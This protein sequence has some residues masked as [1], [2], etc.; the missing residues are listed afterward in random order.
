MGVGG[1]IPCSGS[2]GEHGRCR[3]LLAG[4]KAHAIQFE[5]EHPDHKGGSLVAIRE[6]MVAG[7]AGGIGCSLSAK[8]SQFA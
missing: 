5:E 4:H 8:I 7:N 2:Q 3:R 1:F 6:G